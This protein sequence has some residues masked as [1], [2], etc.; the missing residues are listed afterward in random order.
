MQ[1]PSFS[2]T[3]AF[4]SI[5]HH[6]YGL[7]VLAN[8]EFCPYGDKQPIAGVTSNKDFR[9]WM[10]LKTELCRRPVNHKDWFDCSYVHDASELQKPKCLSFALTK[11]CSQGSLCKYQHTLLPDQFLVIRH[12]FFGILPK[13]LIEI[14]LLYALVQQHKYPMHRHRHRHRQN[15]YLNCLLTCKRWYQILNTDR[16]ENGLVALPKYL[17][18]IKAAHVKKLEDQKN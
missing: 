5:K 9:Q 11:N 4:S 15:I 14:I 8:P 10:H 16:F 2:N 17:A 3:I 13:Q 12:N 7:A 1:R 18:D 6:Q